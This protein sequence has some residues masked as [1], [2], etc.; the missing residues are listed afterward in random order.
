MEKEEGRNKRYKKIFLVLVVLLLVLTFFSKSL[1]NYQLPVVTVTSPKQG[2]LSFTV[3]GTGAFDYAHVD[4]F[5]AE[6]DGRVREILVSV[7]D[8]VKKGQCLMRFQ[9]NGTGEMYDVVAAESGIVASIGAKQ[10]MYVSSM[11]NMVLYEIAEESKEWTC[12]LII[13]EEQLEFVDL[14]STP[15]LYIE[16]RNETVE[17]KI[18]SISGYVGQNQTGY[19]VNI[20]ASLDDN[21]LYGEKVDITIR[22]ESMVYD[23]L[24]PATALRKDREGYFVLILQKDSG[25][26]GSGYEAHR[27]SVDLL[28]SDES[29]CAVR[30]L[31]SDELVIIASTGEITDGSD[32]FYEGDGAE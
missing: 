22:N 25:V 11:Q 23:A 20:S 1:Y 14:N 7:G 30:G 12:Y 26:L 28:D 6:I 17:G 5:Y 19:K 15:E 31:P 3:V 2:V 18:T 32:V 16:S 8:E 24:V 10:G 29:Y 21:A 27:M 4:S 9:L 13:S